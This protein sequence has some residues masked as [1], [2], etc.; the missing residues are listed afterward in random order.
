VGAL[1][2]VGVKQAVVQNPKGQEEA[3]LNAG[4]WMEL[5]RAVSL[6][7]IVFTMAPWIAHF[8]GIANLSALLR[9]TLLGSLFDGLMS[10][11]SILA[12]KEMK[13]GRWMAISNGGGI[14]GV[15]LTVILSFVL[16]DVWALAIG[17]ASESA[18][19]CFF[20]YVWYPGLPSLRWD[21][22]AIRELY[23]F[24][25]QAFGLSF[26]NLVFS[27]TDIFVLGKLY[28][29]TELGLYTMGV[30][31]V[32]T[33]S[34]FITTMMGQALFP[35]FAHIQND[36]ERMNRILVEVSS[37]L[38]LV[39]LPGVV[40]IFL[41]GHS[42]LSLFYGR[43]Y[44]AAAVPLAVASIVVFFNLLNAAI[45]CIFTAL[46]RP[47]LH[48][49][50]VAASA[51]VMLITVYPACR[52]LGLVGGQVAALLAIVVSYF[53]QVIRVRTLTNLNLVRYAK[54]FMTAA[55][56]SAGILVV[57]VCAHLLGL[58]TKPIA[59]IAFSA[60]ACLVA[61]LFC[62]PV[63]RNIKPNSRLIG[64]A[65]TDDCRAQAR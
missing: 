39:G 19:R 22:S 44:G 58:A 25:K 43:R 9:V 50:A 21:R 29:T 36:K 33:P 30:A 34:S 7:A 3:Y 8:Y 32:F 6:Y 62:L 53:I 5:G 35:I 23:M 47:S 51:V 18:F 24:S 54:P 38:I 42:L 13:F 59:N 49:R 1:T 60:G 27:R 10:P 46:G 2:E 56:A 15:I 16:R 48:R 28:S 17:F 40:A 64:T 63:F 55:L 41:C 4:W 14:C 65:V 26:L 20:S 45:T 37:W 61:Y 52:L 11:R 12:Q 31:L 57:G